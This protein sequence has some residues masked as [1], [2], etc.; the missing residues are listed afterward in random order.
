MTKI[1]KIRKR[2]GTI[3]TL[4]TEKI[5]KILEKIVPEKKKNKIKKI[6]AEI[7]DILEKYYTAEI[8]PKT[9]DIEDIVIDLLKKEKIP[10]KKYI[11]EKAKQKYGFKVKYGVRDDVGLT[12]NAIK[13]LAQ[14]Y[15]LKN[16]KGAIIETPARMFKRVAQ[17][18][19][20]A[21]RKFNKNPKR[22]E[23]EFYKVLSNLE[24]LPNSPT[25]MNAG[26]PVGQ[27]AACFVLP[28]NDSLDSIF[29][30]VKVMAK[31]QQSGGG[32]GF[33]F[34]KIR[35]EGDL[36]EKTK[37]KASG[38]L[39]FMEIFDKTTDVIK[40]GGKRRGANMGVLKSSH[41]NIVDFIKSKQKERHFSNFNISVAITDDFMK[42]ALE[43][44][45]YW[46]VN[47][48]TGKR[49]KKVS[50]KIILEMISKIAWKTG[51]PG[52]IFIDE[53]NRHNPTPAIGEIK[54]TNPCG[55]QPLLSNESCNLGS[56]NLVNMIEKSRLNWDKLKKIVRTAVHFLDNVI[57]INKYPT[58]QIEKTT[59][60]NRKIGLGIMGFAEAIALL[61]I[62]YNSEKA[63]QFA[64]KLMKFITETARK[65]SEEL[66]KER[67]NFPN[68][69]KSS[70]AKKFNNMRNATLTTIAPTGSISLIAG[71]SSGIEPLFAI[72]YV[73]EILNGT[74]MLEMNPIF[75]QVA[76]KKGFYDKKLMLQIAREGNISKNKK[77]PSNIRKT[78]V[79]AM[80]IKPEW[81]V[82]IQAAF[83]KYVD[84]AVS[85]TVNLPNNATAQ[86]VE[87][88]YSLAYK[89]KCKGITV[90]RYG[91]KNKQVLYIGSCPAGVC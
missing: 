55:E 44:K 88:I 66:G 81:H 18:V 32:T 52:I 33:S 76:R 34:S 40:K 62:P 69:E 15:L 73:R 24:F 41:P 50:A 53:I 77:I 38:P 30:A 43:N 21:E 12:E 46:L 86:D 91:S 60:S 74:K 25:L 83:Q 26:T 13:V 14:R 17:T 22:T 31:I 64:E 82:K 8:L 89:L 23:E 5:R 19:A 9:Q 72:S 90:Y 65:K 71:C 1:T 20:A 70:Y 47:P 36:V 37:G 63:V 54:S 59:K 87:K 80:E 56:I 2:D 58:E 75:E 35:P 45:E 28:V 7:I 29:E 51:D 49:T 16:K 84:N 61:G 4:D 57:E 10:A 78:F 85:K 68:F 42:S 67:G 39:S 27:L 48:R 3:E 6:I 11:D 79:T